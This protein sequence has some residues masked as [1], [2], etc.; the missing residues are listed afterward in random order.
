MGRNELA[1]DLAG[2]VYMSNRPEGKDDVADRSEAGVRE[3]FTAAELAGLRGLPGSRVGVWKRAQADNWKSRDRSGA[4]GGR[5]YHL[6]N[7]PE[8]AKAALLVRE[9]R[10]L[11]PP[12]ELEPALSPEAEHERRQE[13]WAS[14]ERKPES[15]RQEAERRLVAVQLVEDLIK[16]GSKKM[17]AYE[18]VA[19]RAETNVTTIRNWLRLVKDAEPGDRLPLLA[20]RYT[21]RTTYAGYDDRIYQWFR[22]R[23]LVLTKPSAASVYRVVEDIARAH[24]LEM[25]HVDTLKRD[26][27]RIEDPLVIKL[28]RE[29][30]RAV[31]ESLPWVERDKTGLHAMEVIN[32]DGHNLDI[33]VV[34]PDGE[35]CRATLI[36]FQDVHSGA[37]VGYRIAKSESAT[38]FRLGLLQVCEEHGLPRHLVL[39]NT[40]AAA[41]KELSAGIEPTKRRRFKEDKPGTPLGLLKILEIEIHFTQVYHG[42]SKPIERAFR[43]LAS[44]ISKDARFDGAYLGNNPLNKP[45]NYGTK[46]VP[47][48]LVREVAREMIERHNAQPG[49]RTEVCRGKDSFREAFVRSKAANQDKIRQLTEGQ[50]RLLYLRSQLVTV[51]RKDSTVKVHGNR[52]WTKELNRYSGRKVVVRYHPDRLQEEPVHI[53]SLNGDYLFPAPIW[54]KGDFLSEETAER[55]ARVRGQVNRDT[56]RL[57]KSRR[58]LTAVEVEAMRPPFE[59]PPLAAA[60]GDDVIRPAFGVPTT[61]NQ[62]QT[63]AAVQQ[64]SSE[65]QARIMASIGPTLDQMKKPEPRILRLPEK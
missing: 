8:A 64:R 5:E 9:R 4:G 65:A 48:E 6:S 14:F 46:T 11:P 15:I 63:V 40:M 28:E 23:F 10:A 53:Y 58:R 35:K 12:A 51:A 22:D 59:L 7:L 20:P 13:L 56:K 43:D 29:G 50:Y 21:G 42:Q 55:V 62:V 54:E 24:G 27:D 47:V 38:E 16:S 61:A 26:L 36:G 17:D 41:A 45:A 18:A 33:D 39:D 37:I 25:P 1:V 19:E 60:S 49:R 32:M 52:Y 57:A 34:W 31:M 30:E 2:Q 44:S 3:W